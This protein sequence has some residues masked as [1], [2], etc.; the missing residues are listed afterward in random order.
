MATALELLDADTYEA[1]VRIPGRPAIDAA[2]DGVGLA[3][4]AARHAAGHGRDD[5]EAGMD[6]CRAALHLLLGEGPARSGSPHPHLDELREHLAK[7][8]LVITEL[9]RIEVAVRR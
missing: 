2:L 9:E 7:A 1:A 3:F 6:A 8:V 5:T 4:G